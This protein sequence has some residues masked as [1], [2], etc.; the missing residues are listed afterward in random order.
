MNAAAIS[1]GR[2]LLRQAALRQRNA[3]SDSD[4]ARRSRQIQSRALELDCYHGSHAVAFYSS[5]QNEVHTDRLLDHALG[6]GKKVFLPR[7]LDKSFALVEIRS[8]SE[9]TV[10]RFGILEPMG[11]MTLTEVGEHGLAVFVPGLVFDLAGNRLGRG[12]GGYD[13]LL[14]QLGAGI[15]A[16]GL[17]YEFQIVDALP[18]QPWDRRMGWVITEDRVIDCDVKPYPPDHGPASH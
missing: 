16:I 14:A 13:R 1:E 2:E 7:W 10:G 9:L 17:A 18:A 12:Q 11:S 6:A 3:L 5:I 4:A 15:R 8:R